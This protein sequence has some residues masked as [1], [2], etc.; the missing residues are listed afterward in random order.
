MELRIAL[1]T[2]APTVESNG[3]PD[4]AGALQHLADKEP[5]SHKGL[6]PVSKW[7]IRRRVYL[8]GA[9]GRWRSDPETASS[10]RNRKS[11]R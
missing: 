2:A 7:R 10:L 11:S 9:E 8:I 1:N 4:D 5:S 3:G 6:T